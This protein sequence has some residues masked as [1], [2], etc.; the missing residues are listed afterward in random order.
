MTTYEQ[1]VILAQQLN[2]AEKAR[3]LEHISTALK[4]DLETEAYK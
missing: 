4:R 1:I 2:V 3:L